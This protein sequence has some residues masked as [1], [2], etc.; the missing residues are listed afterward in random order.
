MPTEEIIDGLPKQLYQP[1]RVTVLEL[2]S[3]ERCGQQVHYGDSHCFHKYVIFLPN[4]EP[5]P[6]RLCAIVRDFFLFKM[7]GSL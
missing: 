4:N 6:P 3:S 1:G 7:V 2:K 5:S